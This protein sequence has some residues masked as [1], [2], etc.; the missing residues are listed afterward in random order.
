MAQG[1][2]GGL[3][4]VAAAG[5]V[6][7]WPVAAEAAPV[8]VLLSFNVEAESDAEALDKLRLDL[9][10]TYFVTGEF[11]QRHP[12]LVRR[13]AVRGNTVGSYGHTRA[14]L[15]TLCAVR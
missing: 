9:P 2:K 15:T 12:D 13:L 8:N 4:A 7:G 10:A 5:F 3:L 6:G 11:A 1:I 14:D